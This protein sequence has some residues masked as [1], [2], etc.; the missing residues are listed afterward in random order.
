MASTVVLKLAWAWSASLMLM[1]PVASRLP[2]LLSTAMSSVTVDAEGAPMTAASLV[3]VRVKLSV[4]VVPSSACRVKVSSLVWP[5]PR[6]CTALS[7][8]V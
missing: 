7:A 2:V 6:N 4:V 5:A 1:L 3:P 8:T